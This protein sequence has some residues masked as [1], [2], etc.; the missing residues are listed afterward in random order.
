MNDYPYVIFI[1]ND[2]NHSVFY[3]SD[4]EGH[5]INPEPGDKILTRF[6]S[7]SFNEGLKYK[8]VMLAI[9][10]DSVYDKEAIHQTK[11][12]DANEN[13]NF[14]PSIVWNTDKTLFMNIDRGTC[15]F[16]TKKVDKIY[17][18][19]NNATTAR[20]IKTSNLAIVFSESENNQKTVKIYSCTGLTIS[21]ILAIRGLKKNIEAFKNL[22]K[23]HNDIIK[24]RNHEN[25]PFA[26]LNLSRKDCC[27]NT[28]MDFAKHFNNKKIITIL[29]NYS[30]K[31]NCSASKHNATDCAICHNALPSNGKQ[32]CQNVIKPCNHL[33][34][35]KCHFSLEKKLK[36]RETIRCCNLIKCRTNGI[37]CGRIITNCEKVFK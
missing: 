20:F 25:Y 34:C 36:K 6:K 9:D 26:V 28:V 30:C 19:E 18:L 16:F 23:I 27:G 13:F 35:N 15:N 5:L 4:K 33:I 12:E 11:F 21:H 32:Q 3:L 24:N 37:G 2:N 17:P 14:F 8:S 22:L 7:K 1:L 31:T 29:D 10:S